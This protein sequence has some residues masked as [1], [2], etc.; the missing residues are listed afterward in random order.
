MRRKTTELGLLSLV[1]AK[2]DEKAL[3]GWSGSGMALFEM[4]SQPQSHFFAFVREF[5]QARSVCVSVCVTF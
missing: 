3:L 2:R 5:G 4:K 1:K